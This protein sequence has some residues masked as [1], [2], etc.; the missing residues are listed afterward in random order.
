[1]TGCLCIHHKYKKGKQQLSVALPSF[2]W[3]DWGGD[4]WFPSIERS[5][6]PSLL[7]TVTLKQAVG[8]ILPVTS[9][10]TI[11]PRV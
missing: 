2:V 7:N 9:D 10:S 8:V 11:P 1:M 3:D 4:H 5:Y 6:R